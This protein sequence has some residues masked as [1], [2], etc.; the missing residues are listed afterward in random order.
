MPSGWRD[1]IFWYFRSHRFSSSLL[2]PAVQYREGWVTVKAVCSAFHSNGETLVELVISKVKSR[3]IL[4]DMKHDSC[5]DRIWPS[6]IIFQFLIQMGKSSINFPLKVVSVCWSFTLSSFPF[7][8]NLHF[9]KH[10]FRQQEITFPWPR[11]LGY[12]RWTRLARFFRS[13][14]Q[15]TST[16]SLALSD[17]LHRLCRS[18]V[19]AYVGHCLRPRGHCDRLYHYIDTKIV[20]WIAERSQVPWRFQILQLPLIT[21]KITCL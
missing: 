11:H 16:D 6:W 3:R 20:A 12:W 2:L 7:P 1:Q 21:S 13:P 18:L 17:R 5:H 14:T 9:Q 19:I 4:W 8:N 15:D 10:S